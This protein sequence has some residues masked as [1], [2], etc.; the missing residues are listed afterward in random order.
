MTSS[1]ILYA[2]YYR[3]RQSKKSVQDLINADN[4]TSAKNLLD[5][6][7]QEHDTYTQSNNISTTDES[8]TS[9]DNRSLNHAKEH[10]DIFAALPDIEPEQKQAAI[11]ALDIEQ[12]A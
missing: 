2:Y 11:D 7:T 1:L 12:A 5:Q 8:F 9:I 10:L 4:I 6:Y 3:Y